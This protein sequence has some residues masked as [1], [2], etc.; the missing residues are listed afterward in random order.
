MWQDYVFGKQT[1]RELSQTYGLDRRTVR[2]LF[3][4]YIPPEKKHSPRPVH[5]VTDATYFG[6]R[7]EGKYWCVTVVRDPCEK[8]N[9]VWMF[10]DTERLTIYVALRRKLEELGYT[11]LSVTADGFSAIRSAF[12]DI[13]F[14][15]CLVHMRRIVERG[16]TRNPQTEAGQALLAL[17]K[18]LHYTSKKRFTKWFTLYLQKYRDFIDE[19]TIHPL[20]GDWSW[21][22]EKLR[23]ATFSLNR[24]KPHLFTYTQN[25]NIPQTT[26]SL[27]GCFSH[28]K[29]ITT[30]HRGLSKQQKQKVLTSILHA[31]TIAPAKP[32]LDE[33]L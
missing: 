1:F 8:E 18:T 13:P 19:K 21:T 20:T 32:K 12:S 29:N 33:I 11:I 16:T 17:T 4:A 26:N 9:L 30:I 5:I 25:K 10:S 6:L 14:Q 22:H 24:L 15:M 3:D 31:S 7:E 27:E 23:S 28:M 2:K